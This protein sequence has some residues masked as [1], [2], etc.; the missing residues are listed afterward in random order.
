MWMEIL[1]LVWLVRIKLHVT[2]ELHS[3]VKG[4]SLRVLETNQIC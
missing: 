1:L 4:L 2:I 3:T